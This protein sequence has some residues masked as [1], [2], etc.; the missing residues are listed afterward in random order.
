MR[1]GSLA[2][3]GA[4]RNCAGTT[5]CCVLTPP[6]PSD[7]SCCHAVCVCVCVCT[8]CVCVCVCVPMYG[9]EGQREEGVNVCICVHSCAPHLILNLAHFPLTRVTKELSIMYV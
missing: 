2:K 9:C 7:R 1:A 4:E 6:P 8:V 5:V 3:H